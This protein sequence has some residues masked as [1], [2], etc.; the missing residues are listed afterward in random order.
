M[1]SARATHGRARARQRQGDPGQ[2]GRATDS[3]LNTTTARGACPAS[4]PRSRCRPAPARWAAAARRASSPRS[5]RLPP[6]AEQVEVDLVALGAGDRVVVRAEHEL[7]PGLV[8]A[9]PPGYG[10]RRPA[11]PAW[12]A[13]RRPAPRSRRPAAPAWCRCRTRPCRCRPGSCPWSAASSRC[14][15]RRRRVRTAAKNSLRQRG[16]EPRPDVARRSSRGGSR[17]PSA[18]GS[19]GPRRPAAARCGSPRPARAGGTARTRPARRAARSR[20]LVG[21]PARRRSGWPCSWSA[22]RRRPGRATRTRL[23]NCIRGL[24]P[25]VRLRPPLVERAAGPGRLGQP[26]GG[27][28]A[29]VAGVEPERVQHPRGARVAAEHVALVRRCRRRRCGS[30]TRR[31]SGSCSARCSCRRRSRSGPPAMN[32]SRSARSSGWASKCGLR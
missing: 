18:T 5:P 2:P 24:S 31:R 13:A 17:W 7:P 14:R 20:R 3:V 10:R 32:R 29:R 21:D 23:G 25:T 15:A 11:R 30:W 16:H 22:G 26:G 28:Q 19:R 27:H 8:Q 1:S 4:R 9:R 6:A 12:P